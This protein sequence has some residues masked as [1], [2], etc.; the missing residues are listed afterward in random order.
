[1][2]RNKEGNN[3]TA[4]RWTTVAG[5]LRDRRYN[6]LPVLSD[7]TSLR[8]LTDANVEK[9]ATLA[10]TPGRL[11]GV[12]AEAMRRVVVYSPLRPGPPSGEPRATRYVGVENRRWDGVGRRAGGRA[13]RGCGR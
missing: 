6:D 12:R 2:S 1:M 11:N 4:K 7:A 5:A 3:E 8:Q 9:L 10:D 13:V